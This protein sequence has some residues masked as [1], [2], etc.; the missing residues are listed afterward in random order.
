MSAVGG[1]VDYHVAALG[2][3][4]ALQNGFQGAEIVVVLLERK[5]VNEQ[6]EFQG[7]GVQLVQNSGDG[8]ELLL[9]HLQNSQTTVVQLIHHR[10]DGG[11]L[12]GACVAGEE[13]VGGGLALEKGHGVVQNNLLLPLVVDE[14]GKPNLIGIDDGDD[15]VAFAD[16]EHNVLGVDSVA[17]PVNIGA[18]LVI[19]VHNIQL[20]RCE[21]GQI[22]GPIQTFPQVFRGQVGDGLQNQ[23]FLL[24]LSFHLRPGLCAPANHADVGILIVVDDVLDVACQRPLLCAVE[25]GHERSVLGDG[26]GGGAAPAV[27]IIK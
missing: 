11:G 5:I 25:G 12:A 8:V 16:V 9:A 23:Q 1:G 3:D 24:H 13:N 19:A 7:V 22:S 15:A 17:Q 26:F 18:A 21:N 2:G 6:N 10:L 14:G 4:A 27:Q 20:L